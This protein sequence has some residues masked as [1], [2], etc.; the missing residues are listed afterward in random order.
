MDENIPEDSLEAGKKGSSTQQSQRTR[1]DTSLTPDVDECM[2]M[3]EKR[4]YLLKVKASEFANT[5]DAA[6]ENRFF[7]SMGPRAMLEIGRQQVIY[8]CSEILE[9]EIEPHMLK[10]L[11][12]D[13]DEQ[14]YSQAME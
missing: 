10:E 13:E 7:Y 5:Q 8:F 14:A 3:F 1:R 11:E 2:T 12:G 6:L 9:Q 4:D